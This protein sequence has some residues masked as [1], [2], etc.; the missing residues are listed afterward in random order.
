MTRVA[1]SRLF[2]ED[3]SLMFQIPFVFLAQ[4]TNDL[5]NKRMLPCVLVQRKYLGIQN[6]NRK[7]FKVLSKAI[8]GVHKPYHHLIRL[9]LVCRITPQDLFLQV[10]T[11]R[12]HLWQ[13]Y[14]SVIH[15]ILKL[16]RFDLKFIFNNCIEE[17]LDFQVLNLS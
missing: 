13:F 4:R 16:L 12:L 3:Y 2:Q 1:V 6:N 17:S 10:I 8:N 5:S 7:V 14:L 15:L 11:L 9:H